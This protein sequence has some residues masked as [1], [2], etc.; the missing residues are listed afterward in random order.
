MAL[1]LVGLFLIYDSL[2]ARVRE[3]VK[4]L[5]WVDDCQVRLHEEGP[6]LSGIVIVT[7]RDGRALDA[8]LREAQQAARDTHWQMDEVVATLAQ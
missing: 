2:S 6:R 1:T 5:G 4:A 7:A 3:A 8:R